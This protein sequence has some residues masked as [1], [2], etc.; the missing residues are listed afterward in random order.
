MNR[1]WTEG[2]WGRG[3]LSALA[4]GL[5]LQRVANTRLGSFSRQAN[6][7]SEAATRRAGF[8]DVQHLPALVVL[9]TLS[10]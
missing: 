6:V 10:T 1:P 3:N 2:G 5:S 7:S 4:L 8:T 9:G